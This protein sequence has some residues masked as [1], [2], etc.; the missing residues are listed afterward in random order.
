MTM[1]LA[2]LPPPQVLED[3][4]FEVVYQEKLEAFR[5]S[6]G[7]NWSAE[8]ESDP[9]LKLIEQAAYGAVQAEVASTLGRWEPRL[10]LGRVRAV[11]ILDGRITFELTG[12]YL[13]SDVTLEVSS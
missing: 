1:E 4:D 9:V 2:A 5:L 11:A 12:Q 10:K 3:L 6:M 8:L 13:G 7:D